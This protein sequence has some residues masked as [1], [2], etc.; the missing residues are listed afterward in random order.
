[1]TLSLQDVKRNTPTIAMRDKW[2]KSELSIRV[3]SSC[4]KAEGWFTETL[5]NSMFSTGKKLP[6]ELLD[7]ASLAA[8]KLSN[9]TK[10]VSRVLGPPAEDT[11]D[12]R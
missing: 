3:A 11:M 12:I 4:I 9:S 1:M 7:I 8:E 2:A 10:E 5:S 6:K